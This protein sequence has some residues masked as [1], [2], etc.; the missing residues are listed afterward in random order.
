SSPNH[1]YFR[2]NTSP[3]FLEAVISLLTSKGI[4]DIKIAQQSFLDMP[5]EALAQKSGLLEPCIANKVSLLDLSKIEFVKKEMLEISK[6]FLEADMV[7]NLGIMKAGKASSTEN[8][9]KVIKKDNYS[10]LKYLYSEEYI[11]KEL[12]KY[13]DKVFTFGEAQFV[14][15]PDKFTSYWGAVFGSRNSFNLD[16]VF[17][18]S[19]MCKVTPSFIKSIDINSIP[20]NGRMLS[21][22]KRDIELVI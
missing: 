11:A 3:K 2:D 15:R 21:E 4:K 20:T 7:I 22:I 19:T 18:E 5:I 13:T 1:S 10:A 14:Q 12:S 17:N 8:L 6:E 16:K 9:F